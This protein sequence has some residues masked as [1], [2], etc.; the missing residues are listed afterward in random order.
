MKVTRDGIAAM[1]QSLLS[2]AEDHAKGRCAAV[3]EGGY[4]LE[5]LQECVP[6]VLD[7]MGKE[8][9]ASQ[10]PSPS[11]ADPIIASV[12]EIHKGFWTF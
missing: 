9:P 1:T 3:L 6:C 8:R 7:E 5:A 11:T 12:Q 4:S 10:P 2:V